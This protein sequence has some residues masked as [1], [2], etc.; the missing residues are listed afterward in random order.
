MKRNKTFII[1]YH[2]NQLNWPSNGNP[3]IRPIVGGIIELLISGR[4]EK[5]AISEARNISKIHS[6]KLI[7]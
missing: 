4:V 1:C 7:R 3:G 2:G 6:S 5:Q